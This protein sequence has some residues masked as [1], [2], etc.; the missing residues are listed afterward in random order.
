MLRRSPSPE[1]QIDAARCSNETIP[2][3]T[4]M[5]ASRVRYPTSKQI[6]RDEQRDHRA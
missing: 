6:G 1:F 4:T 3:N 2:T 5:L